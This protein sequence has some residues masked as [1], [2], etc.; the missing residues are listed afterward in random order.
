V[1]QW[2]FLCERS[3]GGLFAMR[4]RERGDGGAV[5]EGRSPEGCCCRAIVW[6]RRRRVKVVRKRAG[7]GEGLR[8]SF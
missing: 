5:L 7:G 2:G 4:D 3:Q 6:E 1:L 8:L